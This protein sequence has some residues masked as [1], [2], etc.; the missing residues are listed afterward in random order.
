MLITLERFAY[1]PTE[2]QG[3]ISLGNFY[4]WTIEQPWRP[5]C[6]PGGVP[7]RSCVPDGIYTLRKHVRPDGTKTF[8]LENKHLGVQVYKP[9]GAPGRDLCIL[10]P[11][12]YVTDVK[13]CIAPGESRVISDGELMVTNSRVTFSELMDRIP[14]I[15]GHLLEIRPELG[16]R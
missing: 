14:W 3:R 8:A 4:C 10:H 5:H 9:H 15:E 2:T 1:T 7:F 6:E 16:T 11:G 13:G 12:N